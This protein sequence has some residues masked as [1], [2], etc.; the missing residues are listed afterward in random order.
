[1]IVVA[2]A[3]VSYLTLNDL[4][5]QLPYIVYFSLDDNHFFFTIFF[6]E[7]AQS[8]H[9]DFSYN[10]VM[11]T[12]LYFVCSLLISVPSPGQPC[13]LNTVILYCQIQIMTTY[14]ASN[15]TRTYGTKLSI[16]GSFKE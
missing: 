7:P 1:M 13:K 2:F 4:H 12:I 3:M 15:E 8:M 16:F 14:D 9:S 11:H 5:E 10:W 6:G